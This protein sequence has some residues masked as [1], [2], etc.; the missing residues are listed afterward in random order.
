MYCAACSILDF[1]SE[2]NIWIVLDDPRASCFDGITSHIL[3][4]CPSI[5]EMPQYQSFFMLENKGRRKNFGNF[6][7]KIPKM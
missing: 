4:F 6:C 5:F 7:K 2:F 3:E 1:W